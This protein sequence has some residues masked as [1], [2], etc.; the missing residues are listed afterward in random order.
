MNWD[1]DDRN[2]EATLSSS[3]QEDVSTEADPLVSSQAIPQ[4]TQDAAVQ[5]AAVIESIVGIISIILAIG[6]V[7]YM[8][9]K[10]R[11]GEGGHAVIVLNRVYDLIA[12]LAAFRRR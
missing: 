11:R 1:G 10:I 2:P 9:I 12:L 5:T 3:R 7:I 4:L 8:T 6:G